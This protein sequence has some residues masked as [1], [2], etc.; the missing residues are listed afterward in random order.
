MPYT[1]SFNV[2]VERELGHGFGLTVNGIFKRERDLW[3][4]V[5]LSKPFDTAYD[6]VPVVN[7]LSGAPMII[8]SIKPTFQPLPPDLILSNPTDPVKLYRN[9]DGLEFILRKPIANHWMTQV[10]YDLGHSYGTFG[11]LFFDH[12]GS[13]YLNPNNLINIDGDQQL[14]R[15]HIAHVL[16]MYQLPYGIQLSGHYQFLSG[17][18]IATTF[19]GGAGATGATYARFL[20]RDYPAI[21]TSAFIDVPV[22]P[23]GTLRTK[24]QR[25]LDFRLDKHTMLG[26]SRSFDVMVDLFNV[27]NTN[28]VVRVQSLNTALTNFM[29]PAEI[30][31]PRAARIGV[32]LNF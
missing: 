22:Q 19:S 4:R 32:R 31:T 3:S 1:D 20:A 23:A 18:P 10:S 14:D 27:F 30:L 9:Y 17:M 16:G 8:Y 11:T 6:I 26:G 15:R 5:D 29:R 24:A 13:P 25:T 12:Q 2:S 21:R 28:T 7:P